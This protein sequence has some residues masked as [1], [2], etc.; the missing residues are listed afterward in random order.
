MVTVEPPVTP[1]HGV[2]LP[3]HPMHSHISSPRTED[4]LT[5][6]SAGNKGELALLLV[7]VHALQGADHLAP[8]RCVHAA[9]LQ[10]GQV[11][12]H[13]P[14]IRD[15]SSNSRDRFEFLAGGNDESLCRGT[16][17]WT[18]THLYSGL[19]L[20]ASSGSLSSGQELWWISQLLMQALQ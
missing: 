16:C 2:I 15:K 9:Y 4:M 17:A 8:L 13:V 7:R 18:W 11:V 5:C 1:R 20:P 6:V 10:A 14:A 3:P 19:R 12:A